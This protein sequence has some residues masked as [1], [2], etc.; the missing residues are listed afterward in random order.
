MKQQKPWNIAIVGAGKV[1]SVLGRLLVLNG[2]RI[3]CVVS[4]TSASARRAGRFLRCHN[5]STALE[6]LPQ[7]TDLVFITTPHASV[8]GVAAELARS[9]SLRWKGKAVCHA[10]GMLTAKALD[11][12]RRR[13]ATVFSFHP[14]QT[15]PR[16]Y[17]PSAIVENARGIFYGVDGTP[18]AIG[19]ARRLA[20]RLAGRVLAIPPGRRAF[21][22]ASCVVASNH[23]TA[24][25][26][27]LS[28]M[29]A[30]LGKPSVAFF[31]LYEP[32]IAATLKNVARSGPARALSGPVARG[33]L[34]T[35]D[36]HCAAVRR[37]TPELFPLFAAMTLQTVRL[38]LVKGSITGER[39]GRM[40][41]LVRSH[42][43]DHSHAE[44]KK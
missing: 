38:A 20:R 22:H 39:A 8:A 13:G 23:L 5:V 37:V 40:I 3:V 21:Y 18:A 4:R 32:I 6:A 33:G 43:R 28:E 12:L 27:V 2:D 9:G 10:S 29:H 41:A 36:E 44:E 24:L 11:P 15:F 16:D 25:L 17:A 7:E 26:S 30:A 31:P 34:E 42:I 1:G 14:L 35:V 19:V